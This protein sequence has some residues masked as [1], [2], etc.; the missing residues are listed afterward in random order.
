MYIVLRDLHISK[1][2]HAAMRSLVVECCLKH[3][4][5]SIFLFTGEIFRYMNAIDMAD[6]LFL[7]ELVQTIN[8]RVC[9]PFTSACSSCS[10]C[11]TEPDFSPQEAAGKESGV[12]GEDW[13]RVDDLPISKLVLYAHN[14]NLINP[15]VVDGDVAFVELRQTGC[16]EALFEIVRQTYGRLDKVINESALYGQAHWWPVRMRWCN[17]LCYEGEHEFVFERGLTAIRGANMSG[18]SSLI[19]IYLYGLYGL[20]MRKRIRWINRVQKEPAWIKVTFVVGGVQHVIVTDFVAATVVLDGDGEGAYARVAELLEVQDK[21]DCYGCFMLQH[22]PY[23]LNALLCKRKLEEVADLV[24]ARL[25][26]FSIRPM[27]GSFAV[28]KKGNLYGF[29]QSSFGQKFLVELAIRLS[30]MPAQPVIF[31]DEGMSSLDDEHLGY[32]IRMLRD[33]GACVYVIGHRRELEQMVDRVV[34][35][36]NGIK[37][38]I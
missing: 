24:N 25:Y 1:D 12:Y 13:T 6:V 31:V 11:S 30:V 4:R 7:E 23:S 10:T 16:S 36:E 8:A 33:T 22:R 26:G 21:G 15:P 14:D 2:S 37:L 29:D 35:V 19:D 18:K 17:V 3:G 38:N 5:D 9:A 20:E 32:A 34:V 28:L 27:G